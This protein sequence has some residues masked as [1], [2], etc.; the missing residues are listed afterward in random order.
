MAATSL[1]NGGAREPF[2]R[3]A[4]MAL[5][6]S[7]GITN[8]GMACGAATSAIHV[9]LMTP[10]ANSAANTPQEPAEGSKTGPWRSRLHMTPEV[11]ALLG[12]RDWLISQSSW[13][14]SDRTA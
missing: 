6:E 3:T 4:C 14:A 9:R 7:L 5:L 1:P 13:P 8:P 2:Y 12:R 10:R 11:V